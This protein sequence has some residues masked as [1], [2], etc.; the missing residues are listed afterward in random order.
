MV[1]GGEADEPHLSPLLTRMLAQGRG[2]VL[3][4]GSADSGVTAMVS[5][6]ARL[7]GVAPRFTVVDRCSTPL[8]ACQQFAT[9]HGIDLQVVQSDLLGGSITGSFDLIVAHS[10]LQFFTVDQRQEALSALRRLLSPKG[11]LLMVSR[12]ASP[13]RDKS[14]HARAP[15]EWAQT[16]T[17]AIQGGLSERE[18]QPPFSEA[19]LSEVVNDYVRRNGFHVSPHDSEQGLRD[20]LEGAGYRIDLMMPVGKGMEFMKD[21]RISR[22]GRQGLVAVASNA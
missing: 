16:L 12:L 11:Q 20:D 21:G 10:V 15:D 4:A 2:Q 13:D 18:L 7:A 14:D 6:A 9:E 17:T 8:L 22:T 1:G 5:R 19:E 3:I